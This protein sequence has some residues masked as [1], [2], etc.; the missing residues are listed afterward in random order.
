MRRRLVGKKFFIASLGVATVSYV[1]AACSADSSVSNVN[2]GSD[3]N[4]FPESQP[5]QVYFGD[6]G[7]VDVNYPP[8]GNQFFPPDAS[9]ASDASTDSADGG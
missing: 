1:T 9:D 4:T 8:D 6:I 7:N 3:G 2:L 5:D